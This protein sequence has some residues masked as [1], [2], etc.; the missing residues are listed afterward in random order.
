MIPNK[1]EDWLLGGPWKRKEGNFFKLAYAKSLE[2]FTLYTDLN[3]EERNT[4]ELAHLI[5]VKDLNHLHRPDF[6]CDEFIGEYDSSNETEQ[7]G[8]LSFKSAL[9]ELEV[10]VIE[11]TINKHLNYPVLLEQFGDPNYTFDDHYTY[12]ARTGFLYF[13]TENGTPYP[14]PEQTTPESVFEYWNSFL[15]KFDHWKNVEV[16]WKELQ[17]KYQILRQEN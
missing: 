17:W 3:G 13:L 10:G 9:I 6:G 16:V 7:R 15:S 12:G 5:Q 8:R 11:N 2:P 14:S 4:H 1:L